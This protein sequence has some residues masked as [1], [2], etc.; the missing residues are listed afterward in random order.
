MPEKANKFHFIYKHQS[1]DSAD[2]SVVLRKILRSHQGSMGKNDLNSDIHMEHRRV[3]CREFTIPGID[4][5]GR[6]QW[7]VLSD[8]GQFCASK[9]K[10]KDTIGSFSN[11]Q[12]SEG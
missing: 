5:C 10:P 3:A 6:L 1:I 2:S 7:H 9:A 12:S 8:L 4:P 11:K